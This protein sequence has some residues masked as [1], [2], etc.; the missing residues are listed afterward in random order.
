HQFLIALE[1]SSRDNKLDAPLLSISG[2]QRETGE[3]LVEGSGTMELDAT[4]DGGLK[5]ID[6]REASAI[7]RSL[8]RF[9]VQAAFRYHRRPAAASGRG[10]QPKL[11][12]EWTQFPDNSV[13]SA[14]VERATVTTLLNIE[15]KSLTE[16]SLKV[17][18]HAQPFVRVELPANAN[19]V[20]A[21][22]E[23]EKVSPVLGADGSRVPLLRS[24]FQPSGAYTVSFVYTS[25]SARFLK[26]GSYE[27]SLP[28]MDVPLSLVTWEVFLPDRF[29]VRQFGGN[30]FSMSLFPAQSADSLFVDGEA[31]N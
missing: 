14:I 24:G 30:A 26:K 10:E 12:L 4:A 17:R 29:E 19:L 20:S 1:K 22:V 23:G 18:N 5:R 11:G 15:G 13:L 16:V 6:V 7:A 31:S 27:L 9:P 2:A 3:A 8:A 25:S 21:E 28:K